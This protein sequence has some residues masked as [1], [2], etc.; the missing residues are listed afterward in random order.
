M[1]HEIN[2][3]METNR[4]TASLLRMW[5][6]PGSSEDKVQLLQVGITEIVIPCYENMQQQQPYYKC[7][8]ELQIMPLTLQDLQFWSFNSCVEGGGNQMFHVLHQDLSV[9]RRK[10]KH[11]ATRELTL[12]AWQWLLLQWQW[13]RNLS[14][15]I[16]VYSKK[17]LLSIYYI[18]NTVLNWIQKDNYL[19]SWTLHAS[20]NDQQP[21]K[22]QI[23]F[24][25]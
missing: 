21:A 7:S 8:R 4:G 20:G 24:K 6:N 5:P 25:G 2:G 15:G 10:R 19:L 17:Y 18:L 23:Y 11:D 9:L 3:K 13:I 22:W 16:F 14:P 12:S 1:L